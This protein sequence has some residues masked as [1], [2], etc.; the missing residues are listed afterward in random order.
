MTVYTYGSQ[1]AQWWGA[2]GS[3]LTRLRNLH[4]WLLPQAD[5]QALA[6]LAS[7]SMQL[8][9]SVQD[10]QVFVVQGGESA[11]VHPQALS[12]AAAAA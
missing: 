5:S 11:E 7:R 10:G 8:Q 4:V 2:M 1:A 3:K 6:A 12:A 9:L